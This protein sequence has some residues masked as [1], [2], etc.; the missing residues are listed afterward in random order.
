[1]PYSMPFASAYWLVYCTDVAR[2]DIFL[3]VFVLPQVGSVSLMAKK[4]HRSHSTPDFPRVQSAT[5]P[6]H[7]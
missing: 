2:G 1:M 3:T 7:S 5:L 4:S 6:R